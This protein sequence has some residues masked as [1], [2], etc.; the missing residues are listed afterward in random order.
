[1]NRLSYLASTFLLVSLHCTAASAADIDPAL[2]GQWTGT[3]DAEG[4]CQPLSWD[5]SFDAAGQF[6]IAF[7]QDPQK[8][9]FIQSESGTWT[10][11]AGNWVMHTAGVD[12]PDVYTYRLLDA[13]TLE[14]VNTQASPASDCQ[15]DYRFVER[16]VKTDR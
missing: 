14:V 5:V 1:M 16:R 3:R 15:S 2:V 4:P 12:K 10:A 13:D 8:T 7:Y 9:K 6:K 11:K